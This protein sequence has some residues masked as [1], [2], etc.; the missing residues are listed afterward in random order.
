MGEK[1]Y[2]KGICRTCGKNRRVNNDNQCFW[3]FDAGKE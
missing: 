1:K 2:H 3:C